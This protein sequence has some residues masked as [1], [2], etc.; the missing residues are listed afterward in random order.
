[1]G[2]SV[3]KPVLDSVRLNEALYEAPLD[4]ERDNTL[5]YSKALF[6][7]NGIAP[8]AS[9]AD[10]LAAAR[11]FEQKGSQALSVSASGGWTIA[12]M[13]F[14]EI[15]VAEAGPEFVEAYLTGRSTGDPPEMR[16]AGQLRQD[17][18]LIPHPPTSSPIDGFEQFLPYGSSERSR[19]QGIVIGLHER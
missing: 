13:L 1:V 10:M 16:V 19:S 14:G 2:A 7:A 8:P 9:I 18:S 12:S 11:A 15:L 17:S 3:P 5:F 6:T 4:L